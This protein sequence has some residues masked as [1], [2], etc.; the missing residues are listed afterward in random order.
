MTVIP[1]HIIGNDLPLLRV[2]HFSCHL[3]HQPNGF[4]DREP[5][6]GWLEKI[7]LKDFKSKGEATGYPGP[8]AFILHDCT[9]HD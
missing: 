4:T 2:S 7:V 6:K 5:F 8:A 3:C 1:R 9:A